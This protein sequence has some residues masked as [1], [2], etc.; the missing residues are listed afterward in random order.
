MKIVI[1]IIVVLGLGALWFA[2]SGS[3]ASVDE[4]GAAMEESMEEGSHSDDAMM[5]DG[6][7]MMEEGE[8]DGDAM[9]EEDGAMME[10]G[11][12]MEEDGA[13]GSDV[14]EAPVSQ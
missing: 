5:D 13:E 4:D 3:P 1:G 10:D 7:A 2:T 9:M 6:D 14:Q 11:E 12:A 8:K